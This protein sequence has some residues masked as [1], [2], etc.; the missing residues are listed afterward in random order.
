MSFEEPDSYG[1]FIVDIEWMS[2]WRQFVNNKINPSVPG[3]I[4]NR[5]LKKKI[6][7]SRKSKGYPDCDNDLGLQ[8]KQDFFILS[9]KFF[10]FFYNTFGCN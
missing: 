1:Y 5:S 10:K 9:V 4:D 2:S 7:E 8:D 6:E 3:E